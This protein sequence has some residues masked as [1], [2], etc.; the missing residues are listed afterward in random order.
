VAVTNAEGTTQAGEREKKARFRRLFEMHYDYVYHSLRRLGVHTRD[1]EDVAHE[2]FLEVYRKLDVLDPARPAKP[3]LFAFAF[4]FASD[5]R[6]LSR[7]KDDLGGDGSAPSVEP[8]PEAAAM[9]RERVELAAR[10][11]S[12]LSLE[13]RTVFILYELDGV[14]MKDIAASLDIP[15]ATAYSRLRLAREG[16]ARAAEAARSSAGGGSP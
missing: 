7:H 1:L 16:F 13:L 10:C 3:W 4:R 6:R 15:L 12:A 9:Q 8:S 2:V 11:L 14:A 5:Y